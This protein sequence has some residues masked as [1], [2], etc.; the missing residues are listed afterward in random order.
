MICQRVKI[1]VVAYNFRP[2]DRDQQYLMPPSLREWLPDDHLAWFVL[3]AV[4]QFDL[5]GFYDRYRPDG[6]GGAA[7]DPAMML[8]LLVYAYCTGERSSRQIERGCVEDVAYRVLGANSTPDHATV[9]RFRAEHEGALASLFSQVLSLCAEAGMVKVGVVALDGTKIAAAAAK[10]ANHDAKWVDHALEA[11]AA[12]ILREAAQVDDAEDHA[13]EPHADHNRVP[14]ELAHRARRL[15]RLRKAKA[16]LDNSAACH[17]AEVAPNDSSTDELP[18]GAGR[19][20]TAPPPNRR[21]VN[22]TDP[23]SRLMKVPGGWLQAYNAQ[24]IATRE[25]VIIAAELTTSVVDFR[26]LE[27]MLAR[28][29]E[30]LAGAGVV[31]P[32]GVVLA[33][34]GYYSTKNA[35]LGTSA[36]LLIATSKELKLPGHP[37]DFTDRVREADRKEAELVARRA[38]AMAE[39]VARKMTVRQASQAL[40][41]CIARTYQLYD[42]YRAKGP[43]GLV[44]KRREGARKPKGKLPVMR[45]KDTMKARLASEQGRALYRERSQII[46]PVFGQ[47]KAVRG[48]RSFSRRG[49]AACRSEWKLIAATHNLLKFRRQLAVA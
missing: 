36:E 8:A 47:I 13:V 31:E 24:A 41:L 16:R 38:E 5:S 37:S 10:S 22:V 26:E 42:L 32:I 15:Q 1:D 3:D 7:Y 28:A 48:V 39:V 29:N 14:S 40:G 19:S 6:T 27:P 20:L 4:E 35:A 11:E 34:A 17:G 23:A 30:N 43:A 21:L 49:F 18:D 9:A 45:E 44:R 46:E 25:Q 12:R 2:V 33:D